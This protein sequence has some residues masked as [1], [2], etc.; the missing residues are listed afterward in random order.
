[1]MTFEN[2][3][4][5]LST[6]TSSSTKLHKFISLLKYIQF[7]HSDLILHI[8][9]ILPFNYSYSDFLVRFLESIIFSINNTLHRITFSMLICTLKPQVQLVFK[10]ID[11]FIIRFIFTCNRLKSVMD[12][13]IFFENL[14]NSLLICVDTAYLRITSHQ[15]P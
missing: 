9:F 10:N 5:L 7:T 12:T 1:M 8:F 3:R 11:T 15:H 4:Y 13:V 6:I 14:P 2:H